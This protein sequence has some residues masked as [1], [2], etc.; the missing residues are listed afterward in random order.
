MIGVPAFLNYRGMGVCARVWVS[1][2]VSMW[3][4]VHA[5]A[6]VCACACACTVY[7]RIYAP[8]HM[9]GSEDNFLRSVPSF[10]PHM[11][12]EDP[13]QAAI[14]VWQASLPAESSP[15]LPPK[16]DF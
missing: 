6:C 12:S 8:L 9:W 14:L 3:V 16:K 1:I 2:R 4:C 10:Y 15:S 5:C 13:T 7:M 11:G